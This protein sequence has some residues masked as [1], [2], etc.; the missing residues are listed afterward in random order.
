[1]AVR[2]KSGTVGGGT[3]NTVQ[4]GQG[5]VGGG[6]G[7]SIFDSAYGATISGGSSNSV[8]SL[9]LSSLGESYAMIPGGR[10]NVAVDYCFAAGRRAKATN[11]G[12]FVGA[13]SSN[14]DFGSVAT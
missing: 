9:F 1:N 3:A 14:F 4:S 7:N 8:K 2:S 13:D 5:T 11:A 10:D 6:I 12:A